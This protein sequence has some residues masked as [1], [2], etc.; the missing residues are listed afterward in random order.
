M[1]IYTI[2]KTFELC[3]ICNRYFIFNFRKVENEISKFILNSG[4]EYDDNRLKFL[5]MVRKTPE[6]FCK[7]CLILGLNHCD[8]D[9]EQF[10][11]RIKILTKKYYN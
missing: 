2:L 3:I 5:Q 1:I 10:I 4:G 6:I 9:S 11:S 7:R 8:T